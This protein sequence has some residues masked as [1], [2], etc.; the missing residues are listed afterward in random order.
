MASVAKPGNVAPIESQ[1]YHGVP[2]LQ[3]PHWN[4]LVTGYFFLG[5]ISGTSAAIAAWSSKN[6]SIG[7][8]QLTRIAT[9][10][11]LATL[12][13]CPPLLILDLTRPARFHHMLRAF[14]PSS[15][16]SMGTWG[17]TLFGVAVSLVGLLQVADDFLPANASPIRAT[18][19]NFPRRL[20]LHLAG[21][22]GLFVAGYTGVLLSATAVPLWSKRP[23]LLGPLF[24]ASAMSSGTAA[25]S[26]VAA[27][28]N[29]SEW[30]QQPLHH[31]ETV[32]T[33]A[34]GCL[35]LAWVIALGPTAK[36]L[37]V[38]LPG[39]V[40][41]HGAAGAG[42]AGPLV[43]TALRHRLPR[44][45]R[46]AATITASALTLAG[47]FALRFAVVNGGRLSAADPAATFEM[48]G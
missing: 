46:R 3:E 18:P 27:L 19:L 33:L 11:S 32:A 22:S 36:P 10:I 5:G 24:L 21:L 31:L 6:G 48:T 16:M 4:W 47:V 39:Y 20:L 29:L 17:L 45:V 13:P 25:V 42:V 28:T 14:R 35:L 38:G 7:S 12:A 43:L 34:E 44:P 41:R 15:P 8:A 2:L 23:A 40:V 1:G 37:T 9:Y 30:D 26:A